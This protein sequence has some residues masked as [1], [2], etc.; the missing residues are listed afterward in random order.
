M[1]IFVNVINLLNSVY[2]VFKYDLFLA[3]WLIVST[4]FRK[5][6]I[7]CFYAF[8]YVDGY[9]YMRIISA[10]ATIQHFSCSWKPVLRIRFIL[11]RI[12]IIWSV[13]D[14]YGSGSEVIL[15]LWILFSLLN[16][17]QCFFFIY[18]NYIYYIIRNKVIKKK[19]FK[20]PDLFFLRV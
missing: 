13:S 14:D 15:T 4:P 2:H 12:R 1:K 19:I 11:I 5:C 6:T 10:Y 20:L 17:L 8:L 18:V 16:V 9:I 7:G 3:E